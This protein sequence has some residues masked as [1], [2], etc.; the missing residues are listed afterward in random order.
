M[1]ERKKQWWEVVKVIERGTLQLRIKKLALHHPRYSLEFGSLTSVRKPGEGTEVKSVREFRPF[2]GLS[3]QVSEATVHLDS[4]AHDVREMI[5][6]AES[7]IC[8][9]MQVHEDTVLARKQ[10]A[11][12]PPAAAHKK[13]ASKIPPRVGKTARDKQKPPSG[14]KTNDPTLSQK[15]KGRGGK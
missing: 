7:Y 9:E 13:G 10:A 5:I 1:E 12:P 14:Q 11:A 3:V 8:Q 15:A 6:E 2:F 4:I